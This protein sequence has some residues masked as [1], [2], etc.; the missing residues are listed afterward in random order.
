MQRSPFS[1]CQSWC[2]HSAKKRSKKKSKVTLI[3]AK[4]KR[5]SSERHAEAVS[6]FPPGAGGGSTYIQPVFDCRVQH[7][8]VCEEDPQVG[9]R[10]L[11]AGLHDEKGNTQNLQNKGQSPQ[12]FFLFLLFTKWKIPPKRQ[13]SER[14]PAASFQTSAY[15]ACGTA[16]LFWLEYLPTNTWQCVLHPFGLAPMLVR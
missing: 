15:D 9:H 16:V 12:R 7:G 2:S 13:S 14:L 5:K 4:K 8:E 11:G 10:A 6:S 3:Q 1:S